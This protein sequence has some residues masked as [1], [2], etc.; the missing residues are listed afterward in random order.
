MTNLIC[1]MGRVVCRG[2]IKKVLEGRAAQL[3]AQCE[4]VL[5]AAQ[6]LFALV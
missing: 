4:A 3:E 1:L 2:G 6:Q 5:L